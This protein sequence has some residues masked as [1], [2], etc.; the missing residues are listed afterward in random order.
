MASNDFTEQQS[1][2]GEVLVVVGKSPSLSA[3]WDAER[4]F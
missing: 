2:K 1:E 4:L 3:S